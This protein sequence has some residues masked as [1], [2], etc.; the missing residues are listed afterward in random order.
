MKSEFEGFVLA[1]GKSSRMGEDKAFLK[2]EDETFLERAVE[3][4]Q[5]VCGQK[6]KIVLNKNR[7]HFIEENRL[8]ASHIF[9]IIEN[10]GALSGLHAA[11]KNCL[12]EFAAVL[13]VDMP[14]VTGEFF[15]RLAQT[16]LISKDISAVVP[17]QYDKK[18]QPLCAV[19]RVTNCL[20][21]LENL[22]HD[23]STASVRDFLKLINVRFIEAKNLFNDNRNLLSN[24]NTPSE[25][26]NFIE[27]L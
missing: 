9:D 18:I 21:E 4:L 27:K 12:T 3:I 20:P 23:N 13:A 6:V 16:A 7:T 22:L 1:G 24:V 19:Y 11:L 15:L 5:T 25:Y 26:K 8:P 17:V 2:I 14:L 10:R